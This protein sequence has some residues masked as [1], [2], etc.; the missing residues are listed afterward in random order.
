MIEWKK[1]K[2]KEILKYYGNKSKEFKEENI[3]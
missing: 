2:K 1:I 3:R